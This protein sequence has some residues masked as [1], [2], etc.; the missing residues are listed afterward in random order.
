[1]SGL[2]HREPMELIGISAASGSAWRVGMGRLHRFPLTP[3]VEG[4]DRV[5]CGANCA[6]Q[7]GVTGLLDRLS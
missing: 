6:E 4:D 5:F 2:Y 3:G 1:M 7:V